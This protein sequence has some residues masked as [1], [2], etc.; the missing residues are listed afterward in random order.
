MAEQEVV[1]HTKLVYKIWNSKEHG[2]WHKFK[3]FII[4]ILII[5]F[6]VSLSIW[7]HERSEHAHQQE[8]VKAFLLGLK[9][10]L[11]QDIKE[12]EN[13]KDAFIGSKNA[14]LYINSIKVN[15]VLNIDSIRKHGQ[16]LFNSTILLPNNGR[17]EGFK[18]SGKLGTIENKELQND[19]TDL[20]QEDIPNLILQETY[21]NAIK[22]QLR[23][24]CNEN[25]KR[26]PDNTN[27]LNL[28]LSTDHAQNIAYSLLEVD[29]IIDCYNRCIARNKKIIGQISRTYENP[30]GD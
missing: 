8:E 4:E 15:E 1:K 24:Y 13:D 17:F 12:M 19:I 23:D 18:S 10:D 27:N 9:G 14:Y 29:P 3:E 22:K 5:V 28:V 25:I 21:Y 2:F 16:R 6:A 11:Q 7:L 30:H 26:L 20:Y